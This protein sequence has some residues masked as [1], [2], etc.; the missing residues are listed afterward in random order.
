MLN[1]VDVSQYF[2]EKSEGLITQLKLQ[3]LV[4]YAQGFH[5]A[6]FGE[7]LFTEPIRA[8]DKG[9][10]VF[11]LRQEFGAYGKKPIPC[12][13]SPVNLSLEQKK[14][15][16]LEKIW[17]RFGHYT[18]NHLVTMTHQE[19]PWIE[20]YQGKGSSEII[21]LEAMRNYFSNRLN[22]LEDFV[23][24]SNFSLE[25]NEIVDISEPEEVIS[26]I[27]SNGGDFDSQFSEEFIEF[28]KTIAEKIKAQSHEGC[29]EEYLKELAQFLANHTD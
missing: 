3:K 26:F 25:I 18:A 10:V 14:A 6:K 24:H 7:P 19:E 22:E 4:Y 15:E 8:W 28:S 13:P 5:L 20:A 16:Y 21:S 27:D 23:Q 2:I 12:N 29:S 9:P 1:A 11:E 17:K